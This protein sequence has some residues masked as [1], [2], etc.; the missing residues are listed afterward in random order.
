V[1]H[2]TYLCIM[3]YVRLVFSPWTR[4]T[5]CD[6]RHTLT[7]IFSENYTLYFILYTLWLILVSYILY[8]ISYILYLISYILYLI[9]YIFIF[10]YYM[11]LNYNYLQN[12]LRLC[13]MPYAICHMLLTPTPYLN[14]LLLCHISYVTNTTLLKPNFLILKYLLNPSFQW[15]LMVSLGYHLRQLQSCSV[16]SRQIW[17]Y[18]GRCMLYKTHTHIK[19]ISNSVFWTYLHT[20]YVSFIHIIPY[21]PST[22]YM[23]PQVGVI[24]HNNRRC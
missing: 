21:I 6:I 12:P 5:T 2:V 23:T 13:H 16:S 7:G 3:M 15:R 4:H 24:C 1:I 11:T 14:P 22:I 17:L 18:P 19:P 9:S 10:Y 20:T 8:L